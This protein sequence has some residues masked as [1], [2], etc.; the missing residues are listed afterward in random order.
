MNPSRAPSAR[1]VVVLGEEPF[2]TGFALAGAR[3]RAASSPEEVAAAWEAVR[4]VAG[5]V[6]LTTAAAAALG[7]A[8]TAP[9]APLT[10][11]LP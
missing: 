3:V 8:R 11:V 2:V 10:V 1:E 4:A 5:L 6:L 9:G 7:E